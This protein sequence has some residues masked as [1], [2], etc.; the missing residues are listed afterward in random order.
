ML[1]AMAVPITFS[2]SHSCG[3]LSLQHPSSQVTGKPVAWK[4]VT[5]WLGSPTGLK[6]LEEI[7]PELAELSR[8]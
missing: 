2:V 7:F 8:S 5:Q 6:S 4:L 1:A 3:W